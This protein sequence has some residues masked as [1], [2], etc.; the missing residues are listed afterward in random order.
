M[1]GICG[2]HAAD[3]SEAPVHKMLDVMRRRGPHGAGLW[4]A[5]GIVIGHR[6]LAIVD[7]SERG[8]QPM[9]DPDAALIIS[10]NG[11]IYNY[12]ELRAEL[13]RDGAVFQSDCD[14]E[15]VIQGY[16]QWGTDSFARYNGMFA[17]ALWDAHQR[18]LFLVRD[19]LG[20]KPLYY[21]QCD[22]RTIFASDVQAILVASGRKEWPISRTGLE[23]YLTFEN[24]LGAET[25]FQDIRM[26]LPGHYLEVGA[27]G[28]IERSYAAVES[29]NP[30]ITDFE[31]AISDFKRTFREAVL[32]HLMSDVPVASYLSAG[33]DSS[34]VAV[35]AAS[36]ST[37]GNPVT[38]TGAFKERGWYDEDCGASLVAAS[39]GLPHQAIEITADS[40][41]NHFDEMI[42]ALEEPRMGTGALPQYVVAKAAAKT[43]RAI[44]TGHGGDELFSGYPVFKFVL[45][46]R[47]WR[48][49]PITF[50]RLAAS[51]RLSEWPHILYF[52]ARAI[53]NPN[54]HSF[55]PRLFSPAQQEQALQPEFKWGESKHGGHL[56]KLKD[57]AQS[58]C[59][60]ASG[61]TRLLHE[62]LKTYLPGLLLVEDKISMAHGLE[63]RTPYL[64]N[65]MISLALSIDE[66]TK[67]KN[68]WL[69]A[70]PK[71][72]A[73]G[74]L[75]DALYAMPKRGFP[76]PLSK[77]LRGEL[78]GWMKARLTGPNTPLTMIFKR[79]FLENI[80]ATYTRSWRRY[81]RPLD[82]IATHQ[83]WIL[84]CIESWL[85]Q[86]QELLGV[87]LMP[88]GTTGS[89]QAN[90]SII[91]S[92]FRSAC[93]PYAENSEFWP[94]DAF[95]DTPNGN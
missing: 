49:M 64:D 48:T 63:S 69:K 92:G 71:A 11:E 42:F 19:R 56:S 79:D 61:Y 14:S 78:A 3:A 59:P 75:P 20:I 31:K 81:V 10:V 44:L 12:P 62:Y 84:L 86:T 51:T 40:F 13:E 21:W 55:L 52:A 94:S 68:G 50:I 35:T 26:L 74:I 45:L 7:L 17:F 87:R 66:R 5:E 73:R 6:R 36:M 16:R 82:E 41:L 1:C 8:H 33:F 58:A 34:L 43:H 4:S 47:I 65:E 38:F 89:Q 30:L 91:G 39:V 54:N 53:L 2:I 80:V 76:N 83:I 15:I 88:P 28:A 72:A 70:I 46:A 85:R 9:Q 57:E 29:T 93:S 60:N 18:R 67:L 95:C 77:W 27:Q 24:R 22:G 23:Q 90:A 32:R 25:M 37:K